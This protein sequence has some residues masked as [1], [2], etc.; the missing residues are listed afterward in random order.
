MQII[1]KQIVETIEAEVV[2]ASLKVALNR[3]NKV[4]KNGENRKP[5]VKYLRVV[6][7]RKDILVNTLIYEKLD[8]NFLKSESNLKA[9]E[10]M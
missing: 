9:L 5:I 6:E 8:A 1:P 7:Y 10:D 3:K 2:P 4:I